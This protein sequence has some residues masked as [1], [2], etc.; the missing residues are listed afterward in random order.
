MK[1]EDAAQKIFGERA[2]MYV[3]SA[4]HADAAVLARVAELARPARAIA[5]DVA[6][7]TGHTAFA[8]A[9]EA[10]RVVATD[11]T[12][13]MLAEARKLAPPNV[14]LQ[15]ADVHRLPFADRSFDVVASRRAPHHFSRIGIALAEMAR[16]LRPG[17]RLVIDDRSVPEDDFA[18]ATMNRLDVL[19][20]ASHVRQ[21]RPSEWRAMLEAAG[22][23]VE[24]VEPYAKHR[25]I[26]SLT[27]KVE[28]EHVREIHAILERMT[29]AQRKLFRIENGHVLH[30]YVTIAAV[31]EG[32]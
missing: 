5:L 24:V 7:G 25:P 26:S 3:T 14:V 4:T 12:R 27:E 28:P 11:L 2:A 30:W 8:L 9:K 21:Y 10:R 18:D 22:L 6:T 13:E 20:D 32:S 16:V 1:P 15:R 17:G 31:K 19:H 23:R 29:E